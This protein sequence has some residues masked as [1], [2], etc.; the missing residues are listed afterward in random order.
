[1]EKMSPFDIQDK[2]LMNCKPSHMVTA[3]LLQGQR[4]RKMNGRNPH[5]LS[6]FIKWLQLKIWI[7]SKCQPQ[8]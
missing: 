1:M 4:D 5:I 8:K 6:H 7:Q 2:N 3:S